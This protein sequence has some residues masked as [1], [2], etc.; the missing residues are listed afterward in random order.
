MAMEAEKTSISI[1]TLFMVSSMQA[2]LHMEPS[3]TENLDVFKT[4]EIENIESLFN[5]T[6][7]MIRENSEITNVSSLEVVRS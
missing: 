2:A 6:S 3:H 4:S 7:K 5:I 1:W